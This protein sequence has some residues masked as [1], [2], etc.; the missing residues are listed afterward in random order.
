M[1]DRTTQWIIDTRKQTA[2]HRGS[3]LVI[4]FEGMP[5]SS[6]FSISSIEG[7]QQYSHLE[8]LSLMREGADAYRRAFSRG[9]RPTTESYSTAGTE[10]APK[11]QPEKK[12]PTIKVK[13]RRRHLA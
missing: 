1:N 9:H 11:S 13:P 7:K 4:C 2:S 5:D 8:S 10:S 3:P 12:G 6:S